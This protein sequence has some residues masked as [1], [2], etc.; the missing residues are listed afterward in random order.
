MARPG[1]GDALADAL[2]VLGFFVV[3]FVFWALLGGPGREEAPPLL[4]GYP[5]A[6]RIGQH[7]IAPQEDIAP[8][9]PTTTQPNTTT[10]ALAGIAF[11]LTII[12]LVA[13]RYTKPESGGPKGKK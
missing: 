2:F 9:S 12:F 11:I 13:A 5:D 6:P 4:Y 8:Q 1:E 3:L 7:E 10:S